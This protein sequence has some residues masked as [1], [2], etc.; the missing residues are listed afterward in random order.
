LIFEA[1]EDLDSALKYMKEQEQLYRELN[2]PRGIAIS[3]AN[4]AGLLN[5]TDKPREALKLA[6]ES[7]AILK[8]HGYEMLAKSVNKIIEDIRTKL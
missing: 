3:L 4:Q 5:K 6:E 2:I 1:L 7:L 8:K